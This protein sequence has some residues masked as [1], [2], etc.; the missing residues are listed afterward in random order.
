MI[1]STL[2]PVLPPQ[3]WLPLGLAIVAPLLPIAALLPLSQRRRRGIATLLALRS[4]ALLGFA[5]A[6]LAVVATVAVMRTSLTELQSQRIQVV[7][8]LATDIQYSSGGPAGHE[9]MAK[10]GEFRAQNPGM[11][12]VVVGTGECWSSCLINTADQSLDIGRLR[13][14]L[15]ASWPRN[16][17]N[18][19]VIWLRGQPYLLVASPVL[20]RSGERRAL[21][22]ASFDVKYLANQATR[23]AWVVVAIAYVFLVVVGL[24]SRRQL[25]KSLSSPIQAITMQV[26]LGIAN[27]QAG[28]ANNDGLE[29]KELAMSV[30]TY[31]RQTLDQQKSN[32]ERYRRLIELAPDGVLIA[33][34]AG[35][36]FANP[37]AIALAGVSRRLDLIGAPIDRFLEFDAADAA[38][39]PS[40]VGLRPG[41]WRR[42]NGEVLQVEVA[43][44][45]YSDSGMAIRQF[46]IRDVTRRRAREAALAHKAEHDSLTGLVNR[47]RFQARLAELLSRDPG[48]LDPSELREAAVLFIDLDGFKPINDQYGHAAGDAVLVAIG[49]RLREATRGTDLVAR[50]G[51]DEFAVLIEVREPTEVLT[52][53]KRILRSLRQPIRFESNLLVVRASVGIANSTEGLV[54]SSLD[55]ML[56]DGEGAAAELLRAADAAMYVAKAS[57]G[58]RY[59]H[60]GRGSESLPEDP[61]I[62]FHAVA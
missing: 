11:P 53:A 42:A 58:D 16:L 40:D 20:G 36:R 15:A 54:R 31:I 62:N 35:V 56:R 46:V 2:S 49:A 51:G 1:P 60:S 61:D 30:S 32:E 7:R 47:A 17:G 50:L 29:L 3:T 39:S 10:L 4:V 26:R 55:A 18:T 57:G 22:I 33:S 19:D 13:G 21:V 34:D 44:V 23:T 24:S 37:A 25:R 52:V 43:E 9:S 41:R 27:D 38:S 6:T 8:D 48:A 14:Q 12:F 5:F 45:A 28:A 59:V